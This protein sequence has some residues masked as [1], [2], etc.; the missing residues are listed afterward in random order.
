MRMMFPRRRGRGEGP[1]ACLIT[2]HFDLEFAASMKLEGDGPGACLSR[3]A[4]NIAQIDSRQRSIPGTDITGCLAR[5]P[6][7]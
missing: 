3:P 6:K 5:G 2:K 1:L 7:V 4:G